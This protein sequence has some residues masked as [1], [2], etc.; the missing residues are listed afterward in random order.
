[1]AQGQED[2]SRAEDVGLV[3]GQ[4]AQLPE[5]RT[6]QPQAEQGERQDAATRRNY[7]AEQ[8]SDA[9]PSCIPVRS[10]RH[11]ALTCEL[12]VESEVCNGYKVK[13]FRVQFGLAMMATGLMTIG[14][15]ARQCRI[16][17]ESI[18]HYERIGLLHGAIRGVNGYRYFSVQ[19]VEQLATIRAWREVGMSLDE[20]RDLI[21]VRNGSTGS[22]AR[23]YERLVEH[24]EQARRKIESLKKVEARL[25]RLASQCEPGGSECPVIDQMAGWRRQ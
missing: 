11:F 22:C 14:E 17:P 18:R 25:T 4:L 8:A 15:A 16:S 12:E 23:V 1:M 20:I 7:G 19:V 10:T 5:P 21:T 6:S 24:A 2:E 3:G 13:R 9:E